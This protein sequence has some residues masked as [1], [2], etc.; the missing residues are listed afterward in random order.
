[1]YNPG[2]YFPELVPALAAGI[3]GDGGALREIGGNYGEQSPDEPSN[4]LNA[5]YA[6]NCFDSPPTPDAAGTA[7][8]AASWD[9]EAPI[10]G[11]PN[12]WGSL[13]CNTFPEHSAIGPRPVSAV[14]AP[15]IL[16]IGSMRDAATPIQWSRQLAAQLTSA[17]LIEVDTDVHAVYPGVSSCVADAVDRYLLTGATPPAGTQCGR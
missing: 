5:L 11:A 13:R 15:P 1:M 16:I 17:V 14:G 10:F 4:F 8:L 7:Q 6:I 2:K 9:Q 3:A 12:A